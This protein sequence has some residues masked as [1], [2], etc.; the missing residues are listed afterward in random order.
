MVSL[1]AVMAASLDEAIRSQKIDGMGLDLQRVIIGGLM[2]SLAKSLE[3]SLDVATSHRIVK[4]NI[5]RG[6]HR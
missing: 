3:T 5:F 4:N 6:Y 1:V 2:I